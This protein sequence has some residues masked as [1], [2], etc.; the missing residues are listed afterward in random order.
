MFITLP[1]S[2]ASRERHSLKRAKTLLR[3]SL[4]QEHLSSLLILYIGNKTLKEINYDK[5]LDN[6][7]RTEVRISSFNFG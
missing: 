4:S 6:L 3:S 2:N 5:L 1:I 7:V